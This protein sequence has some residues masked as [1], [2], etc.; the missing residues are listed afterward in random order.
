MAIQKFTVSGDDIRDFVIYAEPANINYF[1]DTPLVPDVLGEPTLVAVTMPAR[2]RRAYPGDAAAV[3]VSSS[4]AVFLRD[5]SRSSGN[6]LAGRPFVLKE[7]LEGDDLGEPGELRQF[8]FVGAVSDL[9]TWVR[10][11]TT[12]RLNLYSPRGA[13]YKINQE[14]DG[15]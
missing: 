8:T 6:A 9:V 4:Q 11:N 1:L 14:E 15:E 5:P 7:I 3:T 2:T 13:K 12:K 10:Q